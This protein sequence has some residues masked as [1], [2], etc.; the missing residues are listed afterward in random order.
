MGNVLKYNFEETLIVT[1]G[2]FVF[3]L[4]N[5]IFTLLL[6]LY[7]QA[8]H[9]IEMHK[10]KLNACDLVKCSLRQPVILLINIF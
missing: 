1:T 2:L 8:T 3:F 4:V 10:R 9:A 6:A 7:F 5:R